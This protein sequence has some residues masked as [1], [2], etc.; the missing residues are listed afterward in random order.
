MLKNILSNWSNLFLSILAVFVLYPFCVRV[1][2]E[3][4]YGV[5]LLISSITGYFA[6]LQLGVPLANVRFISKYYARGEIDK[7]NEVFSSNFA[8]FSL[9]GLVVLLSGIGLAWSIDNFFQIPAKFRPLAQLATIIASAN[10]ALSFVF[11]AFEGVLH[12]L[13]KFVFL[14]FVKNILLFVRVF[15]TFL[16]LNSRDGLFVLASILV[17]VT[18]CQAMFLYFYIRLRHPYVRIKKR[19]IK[20]AT[21]KKVA[22]YSIFVLIFQVASRVSFNTDAMVIGSIVSVSS[23]VFFTVGNNF[24]IYSMQFITG[25][26]KALMPRVSELDSLKD[27]QGLKDV[28]LKYSRLTSFLVLPLCLGFIFFG[29]DFIAL[30]MGEKYRVVS[31]NILSILAISYLFF[32]VQRGVAYPLLMGTSNLRFP[33]IFMAVTAILNLLL[34]IW[35]GK[36]YGLYGVAWGTTLPN[37]LNTAGIVWFTC[38]T[39]KLAIRTYL[40]S[41]LFIP[42][43]AGVFFII[44]AFVLHK[45]IILDTYLKFGFAIISSSL[46]YSFFVLPIYIDKK[47]RDFLLK[48]IRFSYAK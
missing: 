6:L 2:G 21:F 12:A 13:Q 26:S 16:I 33:T 42:L 7:L 32:L 30:W 8:F 45:Y 28:Y 18:V 46:I 19:Y 36:Y 14:N 23:I 9:L 5:W 20:L 43:S 47:N 41:G 35:W 24:I 39:F 40:V 37:L 11:E 25:I 29:G 44:P 34:S 22:G 3:E 38:R 10:I 31:G 27:N 1:L 48:K 15:L 4:Q 17:V